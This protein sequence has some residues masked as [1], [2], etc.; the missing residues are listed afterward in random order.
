MVIRDKLVVIDYLLVTMASTVIPL[1][2]WVL[3]PIRELLVTYKACV[4]YYCT[5]SVIMP[6]WLLM[7]FIGAFANLHDTFLPNES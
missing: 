5:L 6:S 2:E 1:I 4:P 3:N 7:W